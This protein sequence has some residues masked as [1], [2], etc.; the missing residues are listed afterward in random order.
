MSC[1]R[2]ECVALFG[3]TAIVCGSRPRGEAFAPAR[4]AHHSPRGRASYRAVCIVCFVGGPPRGEALAPARPAHHSPRGRASYRAV[5][6][7]CFWGKPNFRAKLVLLPGPRTIR[8]EAARP[9]QRC[10]RRSFVGGPTSGRSS[11]SCQ[12]A[13]HS[14][15]GRASYTAVCTACFRGRPALGAK[16]LLLKTSRSAQAG[17]HVGWALHDVTLELPIQCSSTDRFEQPCCAHAAADTHGHD[18]VAQ[19]ASLQFAND[20]PGGA[21]TCHAKWMANRD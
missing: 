9:T 7:V 5:C 1:G 12:A 3:H 13:H 4:S 8:R 10:A 14:P 17:T 16:L 21:R 18:A 15:R 2:W 20:M 6:I 11:C 19:I